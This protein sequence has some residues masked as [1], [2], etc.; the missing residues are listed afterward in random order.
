MAHVSGGFL[1]CSSPALNPLVTGTN[2]NTC[3]RSMLYIYSLPEAGS[4]V[5][6][7][8]ELNVVHLYFKDR[9]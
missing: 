5:L 2:K 3:I 7:K 1:I 6:A 4:V 8:Q 9:F